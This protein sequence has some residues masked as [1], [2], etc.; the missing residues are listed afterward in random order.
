M[1]ESMKKV[2]RKVQIHQLLLDI[3][4]IPPPPKKRLVEF[5]SNAEYLS[6]FSLSSTGLLSPS[7]AC[8]DDCLK[9]SLVFLI[10]WSAFFHLACM[11]LFSNF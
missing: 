4:L 10:S 9:A 1:L 8:P 2:G 3:S 11:H 7:I 5:F 6:L